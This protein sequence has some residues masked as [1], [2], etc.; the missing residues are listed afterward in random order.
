MLHHYQA[1]KINSF[2]CVAAIEDNSEDFVVHLTA[3]YSW[4]NDCVLH[5]KTFT[6][7]ED[8]LA[9]LRKFK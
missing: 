1:R 3:P 9:R 8:A 7:F 2:N 4:T 5:S 6:K